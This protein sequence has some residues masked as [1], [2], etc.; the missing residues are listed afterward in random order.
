MQEGVDAGV[1]GGQE[2]ALLVGELLV[3]GLA[4]HAGAL[5]DIGHRHMRVALLGHGL[6]HGLEHPRA[7]GLS[8]HGARRGVAAAGQNGEDVG[9]P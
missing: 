7:L 2:A 4:G 8:H 5:D 1:V 6:H 3:V 9:L